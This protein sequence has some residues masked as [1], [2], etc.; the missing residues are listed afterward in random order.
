MDP[1]LQLGLTPYMDKDPQKVSITMA[2]AAERFKVPLLQIYGGLEKASPP[3]HAYRVEK[4]G[5]GPVTTLVYDD[6]VHVCNNLPHI[7]RPVI[8]D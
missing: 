4:V 6:G 3:E 1:L 5:K 7:M 8:A 2:G